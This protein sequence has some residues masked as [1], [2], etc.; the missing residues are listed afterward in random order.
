MFVKK[1][2]DRLTAWFAIKSVP[3]AIL[4]L[5]SLRYH[6]VKIKAETTFWLSLI[7]AVASLADVSM[8][9]VMISKYLGL[10]IEGRMAYCLCSERL[11]TDA[12]NVTD[13]KERQSSCWQ[14]FDESSIILWRDFTLRCFITFILFSEKK[15]IPLIL[16]PSLVSVTCMTWSKSKRKYVKKS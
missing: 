5:L 7:S 12:G 14:C 6:Q 10:H 4:R 3:L 9:C 13:E 1:R 11:E 16:V 8:V 2:Y 15:K